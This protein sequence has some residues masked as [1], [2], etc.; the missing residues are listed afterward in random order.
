M[1]MKI[2]ACPRCGS[3][4]ISMGSLN[5]GITYG[6]TSWKEEC[7][8]CGFRGHPL[9][10][11]NEKEYQDF[12]S[13]RGRNDGKNTSAGK[14]NTDDLDLSEKDKEVIAALK[15]FSKEPSKQKC[16]YFREKNWWPEIIL[17]SLI[18]IALSAYLFPTVFFILP[19]FFSMDVAAFT[20]PYIFLFTFMNFLFL[21]L[22][23][24]LIE[25]VA[26][27]IKHLLIG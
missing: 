22:V 12:L 17:A 26:I 18:S 25:Y 8:N 23:M 19:E 2:Y 3:Q 6:V 20:I 11:H 14:Q 21:L 16:G 4:D 15:K 13:T 5:A 9:V 24:L 27:T 10:F 7:K 1:E